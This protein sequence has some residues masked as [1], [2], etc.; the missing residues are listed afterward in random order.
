MYF[1]HIVLSTKNIPTIWSG[2]V[3]IWRA[4]LP[5][6]RTSLLASL[7]FVPS[8][9]DEWL[10][11]VFQT[12]GELHIHIYCLLRCCSQISKWMVSILCC[13]MHETD[14]VYTTSCGILQRV[15]KWTVSVQILPAVV[16]FHRGTKW[17]ISTL[18]AVVFFH[19]GTK[20]TV[21][22]LLVVI[23]VSQRYK[24][25]NVY[26][27][28]CGVCFAEIQSGP[29]LYCPLWQ[30]T[31]RDTRWTMSV[32]PVL[33]FVS[34]RYKVDNIYTACCGICFQ[35]GQCLHC[36]FWYLFHRGTKWTI[37]VLP[38]LVFV[39]Q[40]YKVN[41]V[42]TAYCGVCFTEVQSG[43]CLYCLLWHFSHRDTRWTISVLPV[44]IFVSQRY[45]VDSVYTACCGISFIEV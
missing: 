41:N 3:W 44:V 34:R 22:I 20:W 11:N 43:P 6:D 10:Q 35:S 30:F 14:D 39:L 15:T 42:Y 27:A 2:K 36:L 18:P 40:R 29:C 19:R 45:K 9:V 32:L 4:W 31:L 8:T 24:V 38:V 13:G 7:N 33:V 17:T 16:Y 12:I 28:Y 25:D 23:F 5:N 37:P 1:V 21:S 26:T